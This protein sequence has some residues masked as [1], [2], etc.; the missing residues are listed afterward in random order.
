[1]RWEVLCTMLCPD[2]SPK[3]IYGLMKLFSVTEIPS[4]IGLAV[5]VSKATSIVIQKLE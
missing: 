1:M 4:V 3:N 2:R 5:T